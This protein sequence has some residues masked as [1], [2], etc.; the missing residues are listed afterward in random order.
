MR[1][2]PS[3]S[4]STAIVAL[5]PAASLLALTALK[6]SWTALMHAAELSAFPFAVVRS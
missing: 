2:T 4:L 6:K 1:S 5:V 3:Q